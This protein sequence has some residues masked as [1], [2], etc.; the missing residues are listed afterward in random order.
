[1]QLDFRQPAA[2]RRGWDYKFG[3]FGDFT[4]VPSERV[5][6]LLE[7]TVSKFDHSLAR[8]EELWSACNLTPVNA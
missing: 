1:M 8:M 5:A 6:E 3:R 7:L 2:G 4:D